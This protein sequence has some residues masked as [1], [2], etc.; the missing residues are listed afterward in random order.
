MAVD[1][2]T[3]QIFLPAGEPRGLRIAEITTRIVQA[4]QIPRTKLDQFFSRL[5]ADQVGLYFL[6]GQVDESVK[7]VAYIGQT[8]D[9]RTR[10]KK[11]N[12]EKEFWTAAVVIVS[13]TQSFTQAH[14]RYLEWLSLKNAEEAG[15]YDI[16]NGNKG[17]KPFVP[18]PMEADVLDAFD[19]ASTLLAT[20]GFP[21]FE[22]P[23]G[24]AGQVARR[25]IFRCTGP[26]ADGR[27]SLVDDGFVVYAGSLC[28]RQAVPSATKLLPWF[29]ELQESD[30]LIPENADQL[31][32]SQDYLANS[33]SYAAAMVLGRHANGWVEWKRDD[34]ATL[35]DVYRVDDASQ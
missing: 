2:K 11:H 22:P 32:V 23:A 5:E 33:P 35:H 24:A 18:E 25:Q 19:T 29:S 15:R 3:I 21:I 13:R 31:R 14:I 4:I 10:I 30:V 28:R 27:G 7:P 20:L 16:D 8:E 17:T 6:F 12:A 34:G 26:H 1:A 9:L